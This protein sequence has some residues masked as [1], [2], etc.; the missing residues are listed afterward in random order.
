MAKKEKKKITG[1]L[2]LQLETILLPEKT[3][4]MRVFE[5]KILT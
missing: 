1:S 2:V 3:V 4:L 5:I